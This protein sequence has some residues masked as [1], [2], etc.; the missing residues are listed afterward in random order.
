MHVVVTGGAGY[1]GSHL[2]HLLIA[3]GQSVTVVDNLSTGLQSL[4][5]GHAD[6]VEA[7]VRDT[8]RLREILTRSGAEAVVHFAAS[9]VVPESVERPLDYYGNN[10]VASLSVLRAMVDAGVGKLIF[11]S[12]AA[13]YG[14]PPDGRLLAEDSPTAPVSPYGASKL[15]AEQLIKDAASAHGLR[16]GI[17]RYFNVAGADPEGRTGQ[18]TPQATHL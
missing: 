17:L 15:M 8:A 3:S 18:S 13:V 7:D 14:V 1:I 16:F 5:P 9:T 6:F 10:V 4:V 2:A 12:T 11:S